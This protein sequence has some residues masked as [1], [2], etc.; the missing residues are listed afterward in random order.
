MARDYVGRAGAGYSY[1]TSADTWLSMVLLLVKLLLITAAVE[2]AGVLGKARLI[3][4][5]RSPSRVR[6]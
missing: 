4:F 2:L 5:V 3:D 6:S 1:S